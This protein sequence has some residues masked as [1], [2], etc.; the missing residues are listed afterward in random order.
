VDLIAQP[1]SE[2]D[3]A[4]QDTNPA[5]PAGVNLKE[6]SRWGVYVPLIMLNTQ[7]F[8]FDQILYMTVDTNG[9]I[10]RISLS[11][12]DYEGKFNLDTPL[13]GD[14]VSLYLRPP[15]V[16][17]QKPIRIDFDIL[18]VSS[19]PNSKIFGIEGIMKIPGFFAE[20]CKSFQEKTSFEHLQDVCEDVGLGF[21]S[22]ETSTDDSMVRLCPFETYETF[23]NETVSHTYKDDD[24]FFTWY[25]DPFYYLCL[26]N[27]N[28]QF[29]VEDKLEDVNISVSAPPSGM[30]LAE[31]AQDT[32]KG[33]LILTNQEERRG[34][35][36]FIESWSQ[37]NN[38]ASIWINNG[39]KRYSQYLD[40]KQD[41]LEYVKTFADPLTTQG[42]E[43]DAI[44]QKGRPKDEF[45]KKQVKYKWLGKQASK[46]EQGNVHDNY[47]FSA[48]LNFQNLQE[49]EKVSL[50]VELDGMNF[51]IYK[52]MR[53]PILI[54]EKGS[55]YSNSAKLKD[56][57]KALGEDKD[58]APSDDPNKQANGRASE[59]GGKDD[60]TSAQ[61]IG[62]D[63]RDQIKNEHISGYYI[64]QGIEYTYINPGPVKM[65]LNLIRR[66]WPIPAKNKNY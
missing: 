8:D 29:S 46:T 3:K 44:L 30:T 35:N 32:L 24:S 63:L 45:Y 52:Y 9:R 55:A 56:R 36:I 64:V 61:D 54:Y 5:V 66:E 28:K 53:I 25:I 6:T 13:D 65:K 38:T 48:L 40:V 22:N 62:K 33:K 59:N 58:T 26:V 17:N 50:N 23:I 51:Y 37:V 57:D 4:K 10:P 7:R 41:S 2:S 14:V 34:T 39:Y 20:Y 31:K 16:D 43:N 27:V 12:K 60:S 47:I 21:A 18:S 42:V 49:I 11:L 1:D 19:D 15:D